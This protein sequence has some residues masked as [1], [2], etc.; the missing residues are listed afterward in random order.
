MDSN[1]LRPGRHQLSRDE[2]RVHQRDRILGAVETVM[3][4][5]GYVDTSVADVLKVAGVSRQTFYQLFDSKQDCFLAAYSQRQGG[6]IAA[7]LDRASSGSPIDRFTT[8]LRDYLT[9][10]AA[11]PG[12]ARL[13]LVGVYAAGPEAIAKR[14]EMQRQFVDGVAV[15]FGATS[16][17]DRFACRALVAA[18]STLVTSAVVDDDPQAVLDLHGPLVA[19]ARRLMT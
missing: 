15:I 18:I 19:V 11:K 16:D 10:M 17:E 13:Y 8:L 14:G 4:A 6:V 1:R 7:L 3:S 5:K 9:V 2:V 12:I